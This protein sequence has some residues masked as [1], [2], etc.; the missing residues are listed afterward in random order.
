[1]RIRTGYSFRT[2]VG[3]LPDVMSRVKELGWSSAPIT[4]RA[5]T[6]GHTRWTKL[7]EEN[8]V[9]PVYGVEIGVVEKLGE[10][11]PTVDHWTFVAKTDLEPL[12]EI[13]LRATLNPSG[14]EPCLLY[15]QAQRAEGLIKMVG[16]RAN[17]GEVSPDKDLFL[18]LDP[19][20]PRGQF[21]KATERK[22]KLM[23]SSQNFYPR[24]EDLEFWRVA[25]G[26]RAGTQT[27][28]M[29]ILSDDEYLEA[30]WNFPDEAVRDAIDARDMTM[31]LCRASQREATILQPDKPK[32]LREMCEDGA[33]RKGVDLTS[34]V[35]AE[36]LDRELRMIEE[37][38]FE[39][40]FHLV[41]YCVSWAKTKMIVG[42]ARG[43]SCG[44]LVCYLLDIT[45]VD[46]IP[47][48][49]VFERFID[50]TRADLPDIDIDFSD[51]KRQLLFDHV[52]EK[53]GRDRVARLGT[54][55]MFQ[56][57]SAL[58]QVGAVL[59]IPGWL[60]NKVSDSVIRRSKGD[61]RAD[62]KVMDT[63]SD[64][65][66]GRELI[67]E[68][69]EA[70]I[71]AKMEAHPQ[72]SSQHAAGIVLTNEPVTRYVAV[73][74]RTNTA[75]CDWVDAKD[76][77]LL[78]LDTLGLTQLSIFERALELIGKPPTS[79]FL[80]SLPLDDQA[81]FDVINRR[82]FSGLFQFNG[83]TLQNIAIEVKV[84]CLEDITAMTALCRPGP[85]GSGT[86]RSWINRRMGMERVTVVHPIFEPYVR[87]TF[88]LVIYQEQVMRIG[89][90]VGGLS[91]EQVAELR[92][93]MSKS[94][95]KEHFDKFGDPWKAEA[96]RRGVPTDVASRFWDDM[97]N[98]GAYAFNRSHSVAYAIVSY[99]SAWLKA[100]YPV[101]FAAATLDAESDPV[102]QMFILR[103]MK[104]EGVD[105]VAVDPD[106]STDKWGIRV[107]GDN[108]RKTLIGPITS[109]KGIGPKIMRDI[110]EARATGAELKPS[111]KKKLSRAKTDLDSL[112]PVEDAIRRIVPDLS[113]V[114]IIS[115]PVPI[116]E[117]Q[118]GHVNGDVLILCCLVRLHPLDENEPGRVAKRGKKVTGPTSSVNF[119]VRDD[120]AD[121][122]CKIS[123]WDYARLGSILMNNGRQGKSLFAIKGNCP[124]DFRMMWVRNIRYLG[125]IDWE[126]KFC[127][128]CGKE[129]W[130]T[131][132][133]I[134]RG[135]EHDHV[136]GEDGDGRRP[137]ADIP[138]T[139]SDRPVDSNRVPDQGG[140]S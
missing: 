89:R 39:D 10:K 78:K 12:H 29:H 13:L 41:A 105:Y 43:S 121:I 91:W 115:K 4:D 51:A 90:E 101:E 8:D 38:N 132:D 100:H 103:E 62:L 135:K 126:R 45:A 106:R 74:G 2:A 75:M 25:L 66:A 123:R 40:Y 77:N 84:N 42:P 35:Y 58:N 116:V 120:T 114:N 127:E 102:K 28:P 55:T 21:N 83:P 137:E 14:G 95:G 65:D 113:A 54:V 60:I 56:S 110:L 92:R 124:E 64:T 88:G 117:V 18:S 57:K 125:E 98:F 26:F 109:I 3:H 76:L 7:C 73:D 46:P 94:L 16:G 118:P 112:Y 52:E 17:M 138:S 108:Q 139:V 22:I 96:V 30:M 79:A 104:A 82:H 119:F 97:C 37:K 6:F 5:S 23:A 59:K 61:S 53:F 71:V 99:W 122:F 11:K 36:R 15:G 31:A 136:E 111:V 9:R 68:Y 48:N 81:A 85:I 27:Y 69:P 133:G 44:S 47:Y 80:E 107:E 33:A 19:S 50:S 131:S 32:S 130:H 134:C 128:E 1:M 34:Q 72:T 140:V 67:R 49:L 63:L 86:T 87:E 129:T 24:A 93:A 20:T 70:A